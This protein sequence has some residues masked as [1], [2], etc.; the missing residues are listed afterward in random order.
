[1]KERE[2]LYGLSKKKLNL[3]YEL[4]RIDKRFEV[5]KE[6]SPFQFLLKFQ[7][8]T[9]LK[10]R[11]NLQNNMILELKYLPSYI[12]IYQPFAPGEKGELVLTRFKYKEMKN[13]KQF[14]NEIDKIINKIELF[15]I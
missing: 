13:I 9:S 14:I 15:Y 7:D 11:I 3:I 4:E 1:M 6:N 12:T 5:V 8:E 2:K 10:N